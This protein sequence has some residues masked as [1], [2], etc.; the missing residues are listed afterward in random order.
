M[1]KLYEAEKSR[2]LKYDLARYSLAEHVSSLR[3]WTYFLTLMYPRRKFVSERQW[4]ADVL[5]WAQLCQ[6]HLRGRFEFF[7]A[8]EFFETGGPPHL[9]GVLYVEGDAKAVAL[10]RAW[11]HRRE[12]AKLP[13]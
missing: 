2:F 9:H 3:P 12:P 1:S 5:D 11:V 13:R 10:A 7:F 6:K 8:A 4:K